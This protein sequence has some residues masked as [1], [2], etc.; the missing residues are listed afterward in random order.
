MLATVSA[1][2]DSHYAAAKKAGI[3]ADYQYPHDFAR[4]YVPQVYLPDP[5]TTYYRP[6]DRGYEKNIRQ[7]LQS[8]KT[9]IKESYTETE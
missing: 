4:G 3:G 6:V 2:K 8:L 1:L 5:A 9:V 7:Y